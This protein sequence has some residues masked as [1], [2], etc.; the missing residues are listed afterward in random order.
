MGRMLAR[1][2]ISCSLLTAN[3]S[4]FTEG[5]EMKI[6]TTAVFFAIPFLLTSPFQS[7]LR[8]QG[9]DPDEAM[10]NDYQKSISDLVAEVK[11]EKLDD[12]QQ[13]YHQRSCLTKLAL[14]AGAA[15]GLIQCLQQA[16]KDP[17]TPKEQADADK[18]KLD[19][20]TKLKAEVQS[21]HDDLKKIDDAKR[22]KA[23]VEKLA[24]SQ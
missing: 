10:V 16:V 12:F 18:A 15:D 23:Y 22:A 20:F 13:K 11:A 5:V 9:C 7:R 21:D 19:T 6:R 1:K 24:I 4:V 3:V 2:G 17:A 14:F 8:A